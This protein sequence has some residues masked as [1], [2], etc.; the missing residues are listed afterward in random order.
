MQNENDIFGVSR[1]KWLCSIHWL[2][3]WRVFEC[4]SYVSS[5][6]VE[7]LANADFKRQAIDI[8]ISVT[9]KKTPNAKYSTY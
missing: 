6:R 3:L 1:L 4:D 9:R 2:W 5:I 7:S 8:I